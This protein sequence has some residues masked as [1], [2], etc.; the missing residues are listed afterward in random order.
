MPSP[1]VHFSFEVQHRLGKMPATI[2]LRG[3]FGEKPNLQYLFVSYTTGSILARVHV[4]Q[5]EF[6]SQQQV[7]A[8]PTHPSNLSR[9]A[10]PSYAKAVMPGF[11]RQVLQVRL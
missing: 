10:L 4:K 1:L 7:E 11:P 5:K 2:T 9:S 6:R 8:A 3:C